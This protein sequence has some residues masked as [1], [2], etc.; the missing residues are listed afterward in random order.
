MFKFLRNLFK[1]K[2]HWMEEA[3]DNWLKE[4]EAEV[5]YIES[6]HEEIELTQGRP[7]TLLPPSLTIH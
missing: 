2:K 7:V 4:N 3:Y 1:P 6:V 5:A